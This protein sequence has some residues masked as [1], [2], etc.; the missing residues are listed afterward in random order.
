MG[1][2]F[3]VTRQ[4]IKADNGWY[5]VFPERKFVEGKFEEVVSLFKAPIVGWIVS[6]DIKD[7]DGEDQGSIDFATAHPVTFLSEADYCSHPYE[8]PILSP[9]GYYYFQ[10]GE[11]FRKREDVIGYFNK[12]NS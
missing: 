3:I 11:I 4:T 9:N 7:P 1:R 5:V 6:C 10:S 8:T 12:K 2:D